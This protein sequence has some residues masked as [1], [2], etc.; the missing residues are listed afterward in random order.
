MASAAQQI[1]MTQALPRG[2][3]QLVQFVYLQGL[4]TLTTLAFLLAGAQE[5][6]PLVRTLIGWFGNPLMG[7][8]AVKIAALM[9]GYYCWNKGKVA[10]LRRANMFFAL[11]VA[12]NLFCLLLALGVRWKA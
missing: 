6:N 4:D 9:L 3:D 5:A 11:L 1:S 2:T 12:W 10:M 8:A 7:L